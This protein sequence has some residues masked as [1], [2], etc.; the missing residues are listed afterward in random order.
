MTKA[1]VI[2]L[3]FFCGHILLGLITKY[4]PDKKTLTSTDRPL[5]L[6]VFNPQGDSVGY[7]IGS[8]H[9]GFSQDELE[10]LKNRIKNHIIP[11]VK[12]IYTEVVIGHWSTLQVGV[13]R[14]LLQE[15]EASKKEISIQ[16]LETLQSQQALLGSLL[17]VGGGE[18][19]RIPYKKLKQ[20]T[21]VCNVLNAT[22]QLS[23]AIPNLIYQKIINP[24]FVQENAQKN[25]N[26]TQEARSNFLE[27]KTGTVK[28]ELIKLFDIVERDKASF[29]KIEK[30]LADF[31]S[32]NKFAIVIG[33]M[34]L[35]ADD[36]ILSHFKK[37]GYTF[38]P[39]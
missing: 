38:K 25:I 22:S 32:K 29:K 16:A 28:S 24:G 6:E 26:F 23:W 30:D 12:K 14:I 39:F 10:P 4:F 21:P 27:N 11:N 20:F 35:S 1:I 33:M 7:I 3:I 5:Q 31:N 15:L 36:G 9:T 2:A 8:M 34:H 19:V 13:E 17:Q 18:P 37:Q